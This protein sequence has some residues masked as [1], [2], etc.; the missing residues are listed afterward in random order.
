MK[1][2]ANTAYALSKRRDVEDRALKEGKAPPIKSSFRKGET[3][4]ALWEA[5]HWPEWYTRDFA[6]VA[7]S[8][9][10]S[11]HAIN[12][13]IGN[14]GGRSAGGGASSSFGAEGA[15]AMIRGNRGPR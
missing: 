9:R 8:M 13:Q 12:S 2:A 7:H 1:A 14:S 6:Q 15:L 11:L 4:R 3:D 5:T 10:E